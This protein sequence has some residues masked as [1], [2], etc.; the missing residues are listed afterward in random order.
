MS[1]LAPPGP[2]VKRKVF[3]RDSPIIFYYSLPLLPSQQFSPTRGTPQL[4]A[5]Q[6]T[7]SFVLGTEPGFAL[8]WSRFLWEGKQI[9]FHFSIR[10]THA[11][12]GYVWKSRKPL[13]FEREFRNQRTRAFACDLQRNAWR[14]KEGVCRCRWRAVAWCLHFTHAK[15]LLSFSGKRRFCSNLSS[16]KLRQLKFKQV[17]CKFLLKTRECKKRFCECK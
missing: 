7:A 5:P 14:G 4:S 6:K 2:R 11:R 1:K 10:V 9:S 13:K 12:C 8:K 3:R 16:G 15:D 17:M